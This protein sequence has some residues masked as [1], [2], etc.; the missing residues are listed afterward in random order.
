MARFEHFMIA[1]MIFSLVVISLYIFAIDTFNF[2]GTDIGEEYK[3]LYDRINKSLQKEQNRT[4]AMQKL[5]EKGE[6]ISTVDKVTALSGAIW[7]A[8]K[9]P[10][11]SLT[12]M[13]DIFNIINSKLGIPTIILNGI[14]MIIVLLLVITVMR[15][16][17]YRGGA[18]V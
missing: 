10:F 18:S 6:L 14:I 7:T 11:T 2:Y 12:T 8:V 9:M 13:M 4:L 17:F 16:V 15:W 5:G 1:I 3:P